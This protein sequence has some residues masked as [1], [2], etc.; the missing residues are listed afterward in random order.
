MEETERQAKAVQA[1]TAIQRSM[2][3]LTFMEVF[4]IGLGVT[5]LSA[6]FSGRR[7]RASLK[8]GEQAPLRLEGG[9][10]L[11]GYGEG[12]FEGD[13]GAARVPSSKRRAD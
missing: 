3:A 6:G 12:A 9:R 10:A 1:M 11:G 4:P 2:W 7:W 8:V 13:A 5:L